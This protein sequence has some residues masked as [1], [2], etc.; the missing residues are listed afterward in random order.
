[1][2]LLTDLHTHSRF[3]AD[4]RGELSDMLEKACKLGLRFYG[5]SEHVDFDYDSSGIPIAP[6]KPD[7]YFPAA[8]ALQKE[9]KNR[10]LNVLVG[11]ECGFSRVKE[12]NE[13]YSD[14]ILKYNPD[15]VINSV[16]LVRGE[17]CYRKQYFERRDKRTAY[18]M[19]L[20]EVRASLDVPYRYDIVGHIGYVSRR[21]PYD[22]PKLKYSD[23]A[24]ILDDILK[25]IIAKDKIL[26]ANSSVL[27]VLGEFL[28][29]AD[30]F[31]RYY[32]L[33]GR[34]ISFGSDAHNTDRI[35]DKRESVLSSLKSI[36][37][38]YLTVPGGGD[39]IKTEI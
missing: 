32:E 19:Y 11:C 4:G 21:A 1:M 10:G 38:T 5:V 16:H 18:T 39:G 14:F 22:D 6:I 3:S 34:K 30:I 37:F 36:G 17:D 12:D 15:Y 31:A 24:D 8:R 33:G 28:P 23:F 2:R 13:K 9:F 27:P 35:V 7:E 26:E 25:T 29:G 20:E